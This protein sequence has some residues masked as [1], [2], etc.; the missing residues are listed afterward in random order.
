MQILLDADS[1]PRIAR[2]MI[3]RFSVR[4]KVPV[5]YAANRPI[6]YPD[7]IPKDLIR[8][9]HCSAQEGSA[10]DRIVELARP[11][12]LVITRDLPLAERL[13]DQGV[14]VLDDRGRV[15][16]RE[17]IRQLRSLRDFT[18]GLAE[19]GLDFERTP[20]YEKKD[21]QA[22]AQGLDRELSRLLKG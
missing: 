14:D 17:N 19:Q 10:D 8:M 21:Q 4:L 13:V 3:L 20:S 18:V 1:C 5:V 22:L 9:E 7:S 15:F 6:P 11:G 12:D 16:T 2:D